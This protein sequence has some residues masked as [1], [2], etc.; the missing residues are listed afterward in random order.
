MPIGCRQTIAERH[1]ETTQQIEGS[2]GSGQTGAVDMC[3]VR[4]D[5]C[6]LCII[7]L[8]KKLNTL[9]KKLADM[10]SKRWVTNYFVQ[11]I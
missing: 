8:N 6:F 3:N 7:Q 4:D 10:K 1:C 5:L 2:A 9:T 11:S